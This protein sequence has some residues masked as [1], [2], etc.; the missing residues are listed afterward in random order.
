VANNLLL[1]DCSGFRTAWEPPLQQ[2]VPSGPEKNQAYCGKKGDILF[3]M[4]GPVVVDVSIT[5][6]HGSGKSYKEC[7]LS[8][9]SFLSRS[10][11]PACAFHDLNGLVSVGLGL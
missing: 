2:F 9:L 8:R 6:P 4:E 11:E 10:C 5:H 7:D 1:T 3:E